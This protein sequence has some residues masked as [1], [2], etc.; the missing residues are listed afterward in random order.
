MALS[1]L[2]QDRVLHSVKTNAT[3]LGAR[4]QENLAEHSRELGLLDSFASGTG[5]S[6]GKYLE[7]GAV[8]P[9]GV[10]ETKKLLA[11]R[12]ESERNE[13]LKRVVAMMLKATP[14][15]TFFP[16]MT[17]LLTP[18]TSLP[19]RSLISLYILHVAHSDPTLA[20]LSINAYQKDLSDPSPFVRAGA[21]KTLSHMHLPDIRALVGVSVDKAARD[22]SWFVRRAAGDAV[23]ALWKAD[24]DGE[25]RGQLERVI[26][27]L[28]K[29][30]GPLT[31]GSA[32]TAWEEVCPDRWELIHEGF[33]N[34]CGI[35]PDVEEWGQDPREVGMDK[36]QELLLKASEMLLGSLNEAVVMAAVKLYYYLGSPSHI[37]KIVRPLLRT[38]NT[39]ESPE[40]RAAVLDNCVVIAEERPDLLG[41]ELPSFFVKFSSPPH[42]KRSQLSIL[43]ALANP[44]NVRILLKEF[45]TYVKDTD[46]AFSADAITAIGTCAQRVPAVAE[47]CLQTLIRLSQS[48]TG[49]SLPPLPSL[50]S[51]TTT[52]KY[53]PLTSYSLSS[54]TTGASRPVL[55]ETLVTLL[56][57]GR[58]VAPAAR[59]NVY[60]LLGQFCREGDLLEEVVAD[61]VRL[62]VRGFADEADVTKL[63][64]LTL[65]AKS[66]VASHISR[67]S[68]HL[69]VLSL[70]FNY[71]TTLARYDLAYEVRDR[72]RF[73]S[74]LL[75]AAG[76]GGEVGSG[77][78]IELGEEEFKK[79]AEVE[80]DG[81]EKEVGRSMMAEHARRILFEGK[82]DASLAGE[83]SRAFLWLLF[84]RIEELCWFSERQPAEE[85]G[86]FPLALSPNPPKLAFTNP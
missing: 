70:L 76:I 69:R 63:Q 83:H 25:N 37:S 75:R 84:A 1:Q 45:L 67:S 16:L 38:L 47:E 32:L 53:R 43:V 62:G 13:G 68:P 28:L 54:S 64:I 42:T 14:V 4:L 72:A 66:L 3:R 10:E 29:S 65:S 82:M 24:E 57:E 71:L 78:R 36:D 9:A 41:A 40:V 31:L 5:G 39:S 20:L 50:S 81:G 58:I 6:V 51:F 30:A 61:T 17:S 12:R 86:T 19:N 59:A 49:S 34:W 7:N 73:L 15:S 23:R 80:E 27:V 2:S 21:I 18:S 22:G 46:E 33:R 11:S 56:E 8:T 52:S 48:K 85:L 74:G 55:I 26:E 44:T 77:S 60:W 79:G 35:L